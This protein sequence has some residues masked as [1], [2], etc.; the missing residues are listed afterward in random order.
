[1]HSTSSLWWLLLDE[2]KCS[3]VAAGSL[4][5]V[6]WLQEQAGLVEFNEVLQRKSRQVLEQ[7]NK[8]RVVISK[9][10]SQLDGAE[11]RYRSGLQL[12]THSAVR[13]YSSHML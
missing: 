13:Q 3:M 12:V 11:A 2:L 4:L 10:L 7:R 9:D 6:D 8:G 1:M 5:H